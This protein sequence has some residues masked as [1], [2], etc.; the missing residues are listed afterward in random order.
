MQE[1]TAPAD[2]D[3]LYSKPQ[4]RTRYGGVSDTCIARWSSDPRVRFPPPD[5]HINNR[6]YWRLATLRRF[7]AERSNPPAR[8]SAVPESHGPAQR[9]CGGRWSATA[10]RVVTWPAKQ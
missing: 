3:T 8:Q 7:D 5:M 2:D 9:H 6:G 1:Q 10:N 4:V